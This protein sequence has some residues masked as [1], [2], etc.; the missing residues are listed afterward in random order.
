MGTYQPR[1]TPAIR[2]L[3][4]LMGLGFVLQL[5]LTQFANIPMPQIF[6]FAPAAF[7]FKGWLWQIFTY[8]F[9][10]GGLG[11]ILMN[12][13]VL[14]MF[15]TELELRWGTLRFLKYF[16]VCA[17]GGAVLQTLV[18]IVS[19]F[20]FPSQ[21]VMLGAIPIIGA[22]GAIYGF[23]VAFA[24]LFGER[25]V[26]VFFVLP[27]RARTFVLILAVVELISAVFYSEGGVAHLVHL[28]GL[29]TGFLYLKWKGND[30]SGGGGGFFSRKPKQ[31]MSR[32]ELRKRMS[33]IVNNE[34]N[35]PGKFP[36][37]WN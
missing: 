12:C 17:I 23:F 13:V 9:L 37:T 22:S 25:Q 31:R 18:W 16:A 28:G 34:P 33:V 26:L 7:F 5:A 14:Y 19:L 36:V 24:R 32:E 27:M 8:P 3:L 4:I 11:H 6:G 2:L 20:F 21:S 10:H 29:L 35:D 30:L 1:M 15:G